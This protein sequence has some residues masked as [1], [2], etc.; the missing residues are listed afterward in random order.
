M[1][2][3][4]ILKVKPKLV[5]RVKISAKKEENEDIFQLQ[6]QP[7]YFE[8]RLDRSDGQTISQNGK[9]VFGQCFKVAQFYVLVSCFLFEYLDYLNDINDYYMEMK[10]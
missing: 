10:T 1:I 9:T 8:K 4:L 3:G 7:S 5:S 6:K 2:Q